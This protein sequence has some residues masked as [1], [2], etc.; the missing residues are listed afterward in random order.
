MKRTIYYNSI[1]INQ[2]SICSTRK[3]K[4]KEKEETS[5]TEN[6]RVDYTSD[7]SNDHKTDNIHSSSSYTALE[8]YHACLIN[9]EE[10]N[11]VVL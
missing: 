10:L 11:S 8:I 2:I 6:F 3:G 5:E 7:R 4:V 9:G 1:S